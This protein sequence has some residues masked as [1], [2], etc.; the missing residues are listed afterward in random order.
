MGW[1]ACSSSCPQQRMCREL[2]CC[3]PQDEKENKP[4][5]SLPLEMGRV[6]S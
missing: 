2:L 4:L 3:K 1:P 5:T 6:L